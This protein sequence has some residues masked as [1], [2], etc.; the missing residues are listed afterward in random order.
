MKIKAFLMALVILV[1][2]LTSVSCSDNSVNDESISEENETVSQAGNETET[3]TETEKLLPNLPEVTYDGADFGFYYRENVQAKWNVWPEIYVEDINGEPINDAIFNRNR[4]IQDTYDVNI[5]YREDFY[6]TYETNCALFVQSGEQLYHVFISAGH[7]IPRMYGKEIFYNLHDIEY[8]D[9]EQPWWDQNSVESF[10]LR[11]YLPFVVSDLTI[12]DKGAAGVTFF[13]KKLAEDYQV[14]DLYQLVLEGE[15]TMDKLKEYG[16]RVATDL[17]GDGKLDDEDR[18]GIVCSDEPVYMFFHSAGGRYITKDEEG[19]PQLSF[20]NEHNYTAIKYYLENIMYDE[21]LTRNNSFVPNSKD[22]VKMFMEEQGLFMVDLLR[23][24]NDLRE[25]ES[26]FG[27][28]PIPKYE[29]SQ[30]HYSSSVSVFGGSLISVPVTNQSL[31]MTGV[32]LEAM[33]AESKY[34]LIP[35]FYETVIKDKSMRDKE[36]TEMLDIIFDNLV[37]DVGDYYNLCTFPDYFL[38]ITGNV[39]TYHSKDYPQ[40]TSDIASFY[41]KYEKQLKTSLKQLNKVIDSWNEKIE[42]E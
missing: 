41:K 26:D 24:T 40:R 15:W 30:E 23:Q 19:Y 18:Y 33:S 35:A 31:D 10:T 3:E 6:T 1:L 25:M 2:S 32:L 11:G 7:D 37:F 27:I 28:L 8:I 16:M 20:E 14:P 36:S 9:F 5:T 21:Q 4:Y 13:N 42:K 39:Y 29:A 38:R 34:T 17:N 12:L 22:L